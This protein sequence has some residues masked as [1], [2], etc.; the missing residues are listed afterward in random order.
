VVAPR[1]RGNIVATG[2]GGGGIYIY[3][4]TG[5]RWKGVDRRDRN[6][7]GVVSEIKLLSSGCEA[8]M[9]DCC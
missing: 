1:R 2:G 3:I 5:R 4:Y 9:V 6:E 7:K 8:R